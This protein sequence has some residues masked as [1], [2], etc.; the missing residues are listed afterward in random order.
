MMYS[1][2]IMLC[3]SVLVLILLTALPGFSSSE[4]LLENGSFT[5]L[6]EDGLPLG[7]YTDAYILESGYSVFQ[8]EDIIPYMM[9]GN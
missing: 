5:E 2:R 4:N 7:W 3:L 1:R 6:D 9:C 8:T